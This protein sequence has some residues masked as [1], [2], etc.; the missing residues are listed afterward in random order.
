MGNGSRESSNL[1]IRADADGR[2]C[3]GE[4]SLENELVDL[5]NNSCNF[6]ALVTNYF[7]D[8]ECEAFE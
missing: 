3:G 1:L 2:R 4:L 6:E 5:R 8:R 7:A